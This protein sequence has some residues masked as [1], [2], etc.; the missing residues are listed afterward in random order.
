MIWFDGTQR[1]GDLHA[2]GPAMEDGHT[3]ATMEGD[4][5]LHA[6]GPAM[7]D[8]HTS[9]TMEGDGDLHAV[10]PAMEDGH[11]SATMEGDGDL[12]AVGPAMEDGH[13]SATMEGDGDL[14]AVGPAMEDGH[15]SATMEGDGDLHAVGPAME[16]GHTSATMEGDGDLHAVGPAMEDG[17][18]SATMEGDGDLHA[19]GPAMED[20]HT[21]ATMEGDG[22]LHA[23]GPAMEDGHTSATM[24]GDGDLH[25][26]GPAMEDGHTSATM[27]GDGDLHAV[28]PAMEDGHTSATMEGDG[29]LHAVGPAM[30]DGHTSATMEGDGDLHAVGPAMEDGHTSATMEGDGDLHAVGPAMEDG[31]TSATMEGD[32]DLHAVGP[33]MEDGHTSAS[34]EGD[35]DLH[36]VG[37][38]MEDG[39]T[40]ATMEGD[41]DL[42]AVG[43]AMEDGH[44]SA[45]MEGDGDLQ[46]V[47]PAMEDGHT[48]AVTEGT[49]FCKLEMR[50]FIFTLIKECEFIGIRID[51]IIT[52]MGPGNQAIWSICGIGATKHGKTSVSCAHPCANGSDRQLFFIADAPHVLKNLRGHLVRGQLISIPDEI[53]ERNKLPTSEVSLSYVRDVAQRDG[54]SALKLA[55]H[56][57]DKHL[58]PNH[59]EKMSVSSALAVLNHSTGSAIRV[60]VKEGKMSPAAVTT[61]WFLETVYKWFRLMTSRTKSLAMSELNSRKHDDAVEF[62]SEVLDLFKKMTIHLP[63]KSPSWKPVQTGVVISTTAALSLQNLYLTQNNFKYLFLSRLTQDALENLFSVIRQKNAT[64]RPLQFKTALRTITLSQFFQ[65]CRTGNYEMDDA[66]YLADFIS[67]RQAESP[68]EEMLQQDGAGAIQD[69]ST[70]ELPDDDDQMLAQVVDVLSDSQAVMGELQSTDKQSLHYLCGYTATVATVSGWWVCRV[71]GW[72]RRREGPRKD[73]KLAEYESRPTIRATGRLPLS[74]GDAVSAAW[75]HDRFVAVHVDSKLE[76]M[77]FRSGTS[78][79]TFSGAS[80]VE[81][82]RRIQ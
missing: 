29:D 14:H 12:H 47:G 10:G 73:A 35:G 50:N 1:D 33:A 36:A 53:V 26:V 57:K 80:H 52:D 24:E 77:Q 31:H 55:P 72:L 76:V 23:V 43:P 42:H 2:V 3:S 66:E 49:S 30:E 21:S 40:S 13:T 58:D 79:T 6:V 81:A 37:P 19:V 4:G 41:G 63:G 16:D 48:P 11:T 59:Y 64:P 56:L 25:A 17:H 8:G 15:T 69:E 75:C 7:E 60:L 44:T 62:L 27:E 61:A 18:T 51:A 82:F 65:P 46:T 32:G 38:A 70:W 74:T 22:D 45:T 67:K 39:H 71:C 20:G 78:R 5:D 34:M 68:S 28:G 9:A 54:T